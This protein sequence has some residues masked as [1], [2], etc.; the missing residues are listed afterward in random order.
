MLEG[1]DVLHIELVPKTSGAL[2]EGDIPTPKRALQWAG[3]RR[4]R[5]HDLDV[6]LRCDGS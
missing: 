2:N 6:Q 1:E 5:L 4:P 3:P